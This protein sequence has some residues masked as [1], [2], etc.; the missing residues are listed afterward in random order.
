MSRVKIHDVQPKAYEAMFGLEKYLE[1]AELPRH[2]TELIRL[3]ASQ[4]NGCAYCIQL[5][6]Q[7]AL[8]LG[9][10][11]E[12]LFAVAG[13]KESHL[14]TDKERAAFALTDEVTQIAGRGVSDAVYDRLSE[15]F[16]EAQVAQL[17]MTLVTINAWN[18]IAVT[19]QVR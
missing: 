7:A 5:H 18:R 15:Y 6:S 19:T 8:K 2:L 1:A 10:S 17:I 12:R 11:N 14:F 9:E 4:I 13:W 16:S 3:R